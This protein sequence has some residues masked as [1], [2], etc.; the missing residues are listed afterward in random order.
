MR[1]ILMILA[2]M[3]CRAFAQEEPERIS[4]LKAFWTTNAS[5]ADHLGHID[6]E[7]WDRTSVVSTIDWGSTSGAFY[8]DGPT[9]RFALRLVGSV[10]IPEDGFWTFQL[11][12]DQGAELW[13]DGEP[14]VS[15]PL[16]HSTRLRSGSLSLDAGYHDI[17]LRYW[18]GWS[19]AALQLSWIGPTTPEEIIPAEAFSHTGNEAPADPGGDGLWSYWYRNARHAEGVGKIDWT[20]SDRVVTVQR[21]SYGLTGGSFESTEPSDYF[22]TRFYGIINIDEPGEWAFELGSD[23][24]AELLIDGVPVVVDQS[25]HSY[26]WRRG[27]VTLDEGQHTIDVRH[28]EGWSNAGL[29]VAWEGPSD[30]YA[31]IIPSSAFEPGAGAPNPTPGGGLLAQWHD[32]A[33]HASSVGQINWNTPD[34]ITTVEHVYW[35]LSESSMDP[36]APADYAAVRLVGRI[37]IPHSGRWTFGLGSDQSARLSINGRR[38]VGDETSHSMRWRSGEITLNAG[39][40][41]IEILHWEGWSSS[42]LALSWTSPLTGRE[43]IVPRSAFFQ[44]VGDTFEAVGDGLRV[45]WVHNARHAEEVG[46]IDFARYDAMTIEPRIAWELT[47]DGFVDG[48]PGDY[49]ALRAVGL[50]TVPESGTW[51]FG[52]GSDQ[53]ARLYINDQLV[54]N[55]PTSHS[56]RWRSGE[57]ALEAGTYPI[58]IHHWE[59]W[60][61]A[62]LAVTWTSPSTGI[63]EIIPSSALSYSAD[64]VPFDPGGGGLRAYFINN[65]RHAQNVGQIDWQHNDFAA[66][67]DNVAFRISADPF[68]EDASADYVAMRVLG[69]VNVP[70]D[71][72]WTFS[73]GSDQSAMLYVDDELVVVDPTSHSYRWR[74]GTVR[75]RSGWHDIEL[76]HW[77]GWSSAG[78]H[79]A[80]SGPG[81]ETQIIPRAALALRE[82]ES[83]YETGG[84]VRV[85][86]TTNAR[87]AGHAGQIDHAEADRTEVV[88]RVSWS[89]T[90][91]PIIDDG[92]GDY[93]GAR[94]VSKIT[95][96]ESGTWTFGLGSDQSGVL[97]IDGEPVVVDT[98][99]HSYRWRHGT[100]NLDAGEHM[101]EIL[102]W[103]GW[104]SHGLH[105]SWKGPDWPVEQIIPSSAFDVYETDPSPDCSTE[106]LTASWQNTGRVSMSDVVWNS[107][108]IDATSRE[109][110]VSWNLTTEAL[111]ESIAEDY[112]AVRVEGEIVIDR[113]GEWTFGLGSDQYGELEINDEVVVSDTGSHSFRWRYGSI[114]LEPGVYPFRVT[115]MEG[116]SSQGLFA[117]WRGPGDQFDRIIP[118]CAFESPE[119]GRAK[120]IRWREVSGRD[121]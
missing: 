53:S 33:R 50:L 81:T 87:H 20:D 14:V 26:R 45:Y 85:Y 8:T 110:R 70:Y 16:S 29:H 100:V 77:E 64:E 82:T 52:L 10:E 118:S 13:I 28:W 101:F 3:T 41:E 38:V 15:D 37:E 78:L 43:E 117:S 22:G 30:P 66:T 104:S 65:A 2:L 12:S 68:H 108:T 56:F 6:W 67:I 75:L 61:S 119:R 69:R 9:D 83:P 86:W 31:R 76:R 71:G 21:I 79:L 4:G 27:T 55:D 103:D 11:V 109:S 23:Q 106:N 51:R 35:K 36:D 99:S 25:S 19:N 88:E 57:I 112:F 90:S 91:D 58:E 39:L 97:L 116:W 98:T 105:A 34:R 113:A 72:E 1:I 24:S 40:H 5:H 120:V 47:A 107:E 102:Y 32:N 49:T 62:G 63:E 94:L 84:G 60:S 115:M 44:P 89:L 114:N 121:D 42:A 48:A 93:F 18:E 111:H 74:S 59:G 80:W 54:V 92:P 73:V 95:I 96:P 7:R 46:H 17:E